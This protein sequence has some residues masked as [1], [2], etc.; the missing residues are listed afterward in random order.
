MLKT[1]NDPSHLFSC[2]LCREQSPAPRVRNGSVEA[3]RKSSQPT[4]DSYEDDLEKLNK[5][6]MQTRHHADNSNDSVA[7]RRQAFTANGNS[8]STGGDTKLQFRVNELSRQLEDLKYEKLHLTTKVKDLEKSLMIKSSKMV[9]EE[10]RKKLL[11]AEQLCEELMDE[12]AEIKKE[13]RGM[14]DEMDEIQDNFRE[15]QA[16]EYSTLKK[17]LEIAMKNCR[18]LSFKL[19]KTERKIE[20]IEQEKQAS[21]PAAL[22]SQI[23][24]L[25]EELKLANNRLQQMEIEAEKTQHNSAGRPMLNMI[26]KSNS[27]D[28]KYS[29]AS[30][31][32]GGSQ[33]DPSQLMR[34]LQD[35]IEREAD[36]REQLKYAEEE[37]ESLRS[38]ITRI[39]DENESLMVQLKKMASKSRSKFAQTFKNRSA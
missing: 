11:A 22:I 1:E 24:Q 10:L 16:N 12:N 4:S 35:S 23:K 26:G 31:T 32:R 18:I 7:L 27:V 8:Q 36:V 14:E 17:E 20:Q 34:D 6:I 15:D 21:T 37:A 2:V 28:G 9:E 19:K 30:L 39:E 33:E 5:E 25:E 38:K 13:M 3:K 29:R